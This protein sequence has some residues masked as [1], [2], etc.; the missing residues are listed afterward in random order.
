MAQAVSNALRCEI[1]C[2]YQIAFDDGF[3]ILNGPNEFAGNMHA[4]RITISLALHGDTFYTVF[5]KARRK[6]INSTVS[7]S[8][9]HLHIWVT[10]IMHQAFNHIFKFARSDL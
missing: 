4:N 5:S 6:N 7:G 3:V 9:S 2:G 8:L 10:E 1:A